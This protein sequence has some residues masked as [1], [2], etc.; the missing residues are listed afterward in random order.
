MIN[1]RYKILK[2][3]DSGGMGDVY[4]ILDTQTNTHLALKSSSDKYIKNEFLTLSKL[5]HPNI[6]KVYDFGVMDYN[7]PV[8]VSATESKYPKKYYFTME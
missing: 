4:K 5:H 2:K 6:I 1:D 7:D 8:V 3:L